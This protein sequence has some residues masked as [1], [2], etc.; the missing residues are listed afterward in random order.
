MQSRFEMPLLKSYFHSLLLHIQIVVLLCV[1]VLFMCAETFVHWSWDMLQCP[2]PL[3]WY[4]S[5]QQYCRWVI[6][7]PGAVYA[8]SFPCDSQM[9]FAPY[10]KTFTHTVTVISILTSLFLSPDFFKPVKQPFNKIIFLVANTACFRSKCCSDKSSLWQNVFR[11]WVLKVEYTES[12]KIKGLHLLVP[13]SLN[14]MKLREWEVPC[15]M[16]WHVQ[17]VQHKIF[18]NASGWTDDIFFSWTYFIHSQG[19]QNGNKGLCYPVQQY[20]LIMFLKLAN[21]S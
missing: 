18:G 14:Q 5:Q 11:F 15:I 7:Y 10:E 13:D 16:D 4:C 3:N 6:I 8:E 1:Q 2:T 19:P 12:L 9:P 20:D 17:Y 21:L